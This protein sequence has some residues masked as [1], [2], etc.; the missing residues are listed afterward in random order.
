[1]AKTYGKAPAELLGIADD[2]TSWCLN[3]VV[4]TWG[5]HVESELHKAEKGTK[6]V[7]EAVSRRTAVLQALLAIGEP[8]QDIMPGQSI[9]LRME[10]AR[11][12][13]PAPK[14]ASKVVAAKF[15][16]PASVFRRKS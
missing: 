1:M 5:M 16:D 10:P 9:S 8:G 14:A 4:F 7:E 11:A 2:Y 6:T 15:A 3:E 12:S 13:T